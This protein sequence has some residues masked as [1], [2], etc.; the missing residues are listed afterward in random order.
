M[1]YGW[2]HMVPGTW[3]YDLV[4]NPRRAAHTNLHVKAAAGSWLPFI[5]LATARGGHAA[6]ASFAVFMF[7]MGLS[8]FVGMML[9]F[10]TGKWRRKFAW[11][12]RINCLV[13]VAACVALW[14]GAFG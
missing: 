12:H 9:V 3:G 13:M 7:G 5:F 6:Q 14:L 2:P 10:C 4:H 11:L 8:T 1:L